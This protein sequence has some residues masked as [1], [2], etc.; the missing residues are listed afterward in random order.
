M[1]LPLVFPP[2]LVDRVLPVALTLRQQGTAVLLV[3]QLVEKAL[4]LADRVY[5]MALGKIVM[6]PA[7][8]ER[9]LPHRL[10]RAHFGQDVASAM[11][12]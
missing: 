6:E 3:E 10:V 4:R 11:H 9:D 2:V 12:A 1:N 8:T 7:T 5:A